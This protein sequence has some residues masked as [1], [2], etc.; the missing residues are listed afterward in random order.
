MED[1][2]TAE[3]DQ[4]R[5]IMFAIFK[6]IN[7]SMWLSVAYFGYHFYLIR[8]TDHPEQAILCNDTFLRGAM[9]LNEIIYDIMTLTTKPPV[10]KILPNHPPIQP[11]MMVPK[12]LVLNLNGTLVYGDY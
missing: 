7:Y 4:K 8:K 9:R 2:D 10:H 5:K 6:L 3:F 1:E 12:T 11:G